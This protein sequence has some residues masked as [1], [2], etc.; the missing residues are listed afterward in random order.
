M[1]PINLEDAASSCPDKW[2]PVIVA[3][4][5]STAI[6]VARVQGEFVWHD[7]EFE[8]EAFLVLQGTLT[9]RYKDHEVILNAG[10]LHVVPRGNVALPGR[11]GRMPYRAY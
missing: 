6:K 1:K 2:S 5:N 4:V 9:I 10:E 11:R 7:H 3:D 8:D